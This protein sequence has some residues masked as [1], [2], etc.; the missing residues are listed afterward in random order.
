MKLTNSKNRLIATNGVEDFP[1]TA[2]QIRA[3]IRGDAIELQGSAI[4]IAKGED[5]ED[6]VFMSQKLE[7]VISI[8]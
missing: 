1:L 2:S 3:I 6:I 8:S 5:I 7:P 4:T